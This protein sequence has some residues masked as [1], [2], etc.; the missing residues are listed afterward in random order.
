MKD[1]IVR[2]LN[3]LDTALIPIADGRQLPLYHVGRSAL[4]WKYDFKS[5]TED[6]DVIL[7]GHNDPLLKHAISHFGKST[8]KAA[9]HGLY[10]D[11]VPEGL[12]PVPGGFDKRAVEVEERW[13]V[14]R[15]FHLEPNDLAATKLKGFRAKDREDIRMMCDFE[16]LDP[17]L[18]QL[19]LESAFRYTMEKDGDRD[20][21]SAFAHLAVVQKYLRE[22]I[23]VDDRPA[24]R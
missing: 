21:D 17:D 10:L 18:L 24:P 19:R 22:G 1:R 13:T 6:V 23:W 7:P 14:I 9:E 11:Q 15:L 2:F 16:L 5:A 3:D 12:P 8:P 20:R 4:V